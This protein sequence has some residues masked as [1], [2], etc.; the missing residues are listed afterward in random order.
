LA[1]TGYPEDMLM[2]KSKEPSPGTLNMGRMRG[3]KVE[4]KKLTIPK[5]INISTHMK[6]GRSAGHTTLNQ[7]ERPSNA[8]VKAS[9]GYEIMQTTIRQKIMEYTKVEILFLFMAYL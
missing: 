6:K 2:K 5:P 8:A 3:L 1:P 7:S 9:L 4:P